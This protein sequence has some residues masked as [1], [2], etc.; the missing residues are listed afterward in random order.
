MC[1]L[2]I[3][4]DRIQHDPDNREI[5]VV[6]KIGADKEVAIKV[7]EK[8]ALI[9]PTE[10]S[11]WSFDRAVAIA[12]GELREQIQKTGDMLRSDSGGLQGHCRR[13]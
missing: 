10:G 3:R 8:D 2:V 4:F 7:A 12:G 6:W 9:A 5:L 11:G 1:D 13:L